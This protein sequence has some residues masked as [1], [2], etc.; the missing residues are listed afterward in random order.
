MARQELYSFRL[1]NCGNRLSSVADGQQR[2]PFEENRCAKTKLSATWRTIEISH[3]VPLLLK[4]NASFTLQ[5]NNRSWS[6]A[7]ISSASL[8]GDLETIEKPLGRF[9]RELDCWLKE[10]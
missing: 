3:R 9:D 7:R 2:S 4:K 5:T 10:V 8:S 1:A 6:T